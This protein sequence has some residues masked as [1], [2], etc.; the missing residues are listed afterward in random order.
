MREP[1][2]RRL[3]DEL[4]ELLIEAAREAIANRKARGAA[5]RLHLV[6]G[7]KRGGEAA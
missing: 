1:V 6:D 5:R 4:L 2:D 3:G 7:E